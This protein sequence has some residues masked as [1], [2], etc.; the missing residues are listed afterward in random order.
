MALLVKRL[1]R[2]HA[3]GVQISSTQVNSQVWWGGGL[4]ALSGQSSCV[5]GVSRFP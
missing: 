1:K 2:R 5:S 3:S 4:L